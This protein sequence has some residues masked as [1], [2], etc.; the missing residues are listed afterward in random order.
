M[1]PVRSA[2][3]LAGSEMN[4]RDELW[5]DMQ[6]NRFFV[7][8]MDITND[9]LDEVYTLNTAVHDMVNLCVRFG[10]KVGAA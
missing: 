3:F 1:S 4:W 7:T 9:D 10:V 2:E 8:G 6:G 5:E